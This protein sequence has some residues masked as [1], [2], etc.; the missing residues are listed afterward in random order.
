MDKNDDGLRYSDQDLA[1]FKALI[2]KKLDRAKSELEYCQEQI[3][4]ITENMDKDNDDWTE[5]AMA[6]NDLEML[7]GL[8]NR[9]QKF[10]IDLEDALR[11]IQNK[12]YGICEVTGELIDKRRLMA[13]PT[14]KKSL[15]AKTA[16]QDTR[17]APKTSRSERVAGRPEK[18]K[19]ITKI[20]RKSKDNP[21]KVPP[22][23]DDFMS[24]EEDET[25]FDEE[26]DPAPIP[27][28]EIES[29]LE[30]EEDHQED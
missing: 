17:T 21:A 18:P 3:T 5:G 15:A 9:Q 14:T 10:I 6:M 20:I 22:Q 8:A 19:V 23:Q 11:R 30:E 16:A 27:F 2:E 4:D 7:N 28:N 13:V 24:D 29:E 25:F 12:T 1:E 26:P